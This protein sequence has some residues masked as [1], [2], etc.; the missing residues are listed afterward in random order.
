MKNILLNDVCAGVLVVNAFGANA[1]E[2][3][4]DEL[5]PPPPPHEMTMD[6]HFDKIKEHHEKISQKIAEELGLSDEQ[7]EQADKIRQDGRA[8]MK[9]LMEERKVL[10]E[11]MNDVRKANMEEFEKILTEEQKTKFEAMKAKHKG[12]KFGHKHP[13]PKVAD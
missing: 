10:R 12:P 7:K 1:Q 2:A 4:A 3:P 13:A 8:K 9:P 5:M 6:R 11:K